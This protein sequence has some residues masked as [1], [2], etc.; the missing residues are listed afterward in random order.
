MTLGDLIGEDAILAA[1]SVDDKKQALRVLAEHA[2]K[3]TG[4]SSGDIFSALLQRERLS[5]TSLGR[6]IAVPHVKMAGAQSMT[7]IFAR[8]ARPIAF[9]SH[10]GEPVDLLFFLMAPEHAGG[11]H[12]K[13]LAKISRLVRDPSTLETLRSAKDPEA[14][15]RI[16]TAPAA[17][18]AA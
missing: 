11:D 13:A 1:L 6:G 5:S 2:G 4:L 3:L 8:L 16:L 9:D 12:L 10:D 18:Y 7:C 14:I 15:R 17:S